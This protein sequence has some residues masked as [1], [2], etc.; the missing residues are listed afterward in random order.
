MEQR[1]RLVA[2]TGSR[3]RAGEVCR[4]KETVSAEIIRNQVD[5]SKGYL[6]EV[7]NAEVS[8]HVLW[9][10]KRGGEVYQVKWGK[11]SWITNMQELSEAAGEARRGKET[12]ESIVET[13]VRNFTRNK[14]MITMAEE[15]LSHVEEAK[16]EAEEG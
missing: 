7:G 4:R 5:G 3:G 15:H 2:I 9:N 6:H 12:W 8:D 1:G 13:G 10:A 16:A 11:T 14:G